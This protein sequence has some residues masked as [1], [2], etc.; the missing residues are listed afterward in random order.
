VKRVLIVAG[1]GL[2][3]IAAL[4]FLPERM[5]G[6]GNDRTPAFVEAVDD[7]RPQRPV[8]AGEL[9]TAACFDADTRTLLIPPGGGC[10]LPLPAAA[11]RLSVCRID[12]VVIALRVR[13]RDFPTQSAD[14]G[15]L[16]CD[17]GGADFD[18]YDTGTVVAIGC[19]PAGGACRIRVR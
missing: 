6:Q 11:T 14:L 3:L 8:R 15:R 16:G 19:A 17:A 10:Q 2:A 13:G 5:R 9:S 18:L 1:I 4:I 7:L 12:G